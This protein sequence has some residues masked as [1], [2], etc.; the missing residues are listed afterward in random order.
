MSAIAMIAIPRAKDNK[1]APAVRL[2]IGGDVNLGT[3]NSP[4]FLPLSDILKGAVGIVNLEGPI[5]TGLPAGAALKLVNAPGSLSQLRA[6]GVNLA[7]IANNHAQDAGASGSQQTAEA[8]RRANVVPAGGPA[9]PALLVSGGLRI[10]VAAYDLTDGVPRELGPELAAARKL[11][12]FLIASFHVTGPPSY[13]PRPELRRAAEIAA[14]AGAEIIV[15][16]GTHVV[17][18]VERRGSTIIAWGLG[19]LVFACDCTDEQEGLLLKVSLGEHE[20]DS[21]SVVP[22]KA[23]L[24]GKVAHLSSDPNGIFDLLEAIGSSKLDR[25]RFEAQF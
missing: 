17:G 24:R 7:G 5:A 6:A 8:L 25:K 3:T 13:L 11:G 10:V 16:H 12:D 15:A 14:G 4:V 21:A 18:P 20:V 23:G 1:D 2:W 9:G 22:I 19:N